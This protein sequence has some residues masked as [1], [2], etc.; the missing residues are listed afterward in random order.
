[1]FVN[2]IFFNHL[3]INYNWHRIKNSFSNVE[4]K[5]D[6]I[7]ICIHCFYIYVMWCQLS[8]VKRRGLI[9]E[10]FDFNST[11]LT[12]KTMT[13]HKQHCGITHYKFEV[14]LYMYKKTPN[15][16]LTMLG[17]S[18]FPTIY[19]RKIFLFCM[20]S[21]LKWKWIWWFWW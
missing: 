1:M 15:T 5:I 10:W 4:Y 21:G 8:S 16:K 12:I 7:L 14:M 19:E 3:N 13:T 6:C 20:S 17:F 18:S 11:S 9:Q 2:S